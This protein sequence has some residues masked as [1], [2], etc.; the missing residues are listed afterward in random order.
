MLSPRWH[1]KHHAK[2]HDTHYC[3]VNGIADATLGRAGL[4]RWLECLVSATT[5]AAP[6]SND[7][8]WRRRFGRWVSAADSQHECTANP[9]SSNERQH[10]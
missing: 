6:R 7:R 4:F 5:G 1:Y 10:Q 8:T 9:P 3:L 2:E